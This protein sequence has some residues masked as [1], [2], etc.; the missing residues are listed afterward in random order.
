MRWTLTCLFSGITLTVAAAELE[1]RALTHYVPQDLLQTI[2]RK[3]GWTEIVLKPYNGVR[4]GDIAR[5][6]SGGMIDRGGGDAPGMNV[7][8]PTGAD[9][10]TMGINPEKLS[11]S[12][13]PKH[14]Y[15]IVFKSEEGVAHAC[16]PTGKPLQVPLTKDGAR[17]WIGFNDE[18]GAFIDNHLGKGRRHELDPL[19]VRIEVIRIVVD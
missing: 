4:K 16:Q 3:E 14:A 5:I 12:A 2:V 19:W 17:L 6:W 15:S 18:K 10:A 9:A 11:V 7:C 13:N 8:G 1:S